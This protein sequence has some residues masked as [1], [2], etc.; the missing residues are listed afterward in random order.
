M[1]ILFNYKI[2]NCGFFSHVEFT[3]DGNDHFV[4][5]YQTEKG[6]IKYKK[7]HQYQLTEIQLYN[8]I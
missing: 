1:F 5:V 8:N 2:L 3:A 7:D 6:Q 4:R